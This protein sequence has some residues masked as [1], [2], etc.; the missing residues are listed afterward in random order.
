MKKLFLKQKGVINMSCFLIDRAFSRKYEEHFTDVVQSR[1]GC[2]AV[3]TD[4]Y[5]DD[6]GIDIACSNG[7]MVDVKCYRKPKFVKSFEGVFIETY[8]PK[9]GRP[10]WYLDTTKQTNC[11][12]FAVDCE[13]YE[14]CYKKAIFISKDMLD[15]CVSYCEDN[16]LLSY[17]Q[18]STAHGFILPYDYLIMYGRVIS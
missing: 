3:C 9:S 5:H 18:I 8:L 11:F 14:M 13:E 12:I 17:K 10:G 4:P 7:M 2:S 6:H 16:G 1:F 15:A